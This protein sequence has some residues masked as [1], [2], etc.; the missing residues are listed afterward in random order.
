MHG[1]DVLAN[2][3]FFWKV[4]FYIGFQNIYYGSTGVN[5]GLNIYRIVGGGDQN[6]LTSSVDW[7]KRNSTKKTENSS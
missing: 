5:Q 3:S 2:A 7:C 4:Y 1:S 6:N